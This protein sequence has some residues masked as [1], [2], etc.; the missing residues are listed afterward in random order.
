MKLLFLLLVFPVLAFYGQESSKLMVSDSFIINS[1]VVNE[2]RKIN[3]WTPP[4]YAQSLDS[5]TVIYLLDGGLKEDFPHIIE[6]IAQLVENKEIPPVVV[7]GIE[8]T[9][10][11]RDMTGYTDVD[12]DKK[13][14]PEV[15]GSGNFRMFI[16]K[17]LFFEIKNR[18]KV[19]NKK[20]ILGESLAGLFIIE[21]FLVRPTLFDYYIAMDPSLWWNDHFLVKNS[22]INFPNS[23]PQKIKLWFAGS[24][25]KIISDHTKELSSVLKKKKIKNLKW[26]YSNQPKEEHSSIYKATKEQALKW[27]FGN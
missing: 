19:S 4:A 12:S 15:G 18:Y 5:F 1:K 10:R 14:A 9:F 6:T 8:N 3:V 23:L 11:R 7:V 17:E 20:A 22:E 26:M 21:T 25:E 16:E 27:T 2:S 13:I 24:N